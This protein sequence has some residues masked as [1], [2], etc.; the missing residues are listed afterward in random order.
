[1][2]AAPVSDFT[3]GSAVMTPGQG[4]TVAEN[5]SLRAPV[6]PTVITA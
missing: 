6:Q 3:A 2:V 1:M 5:V 4:F